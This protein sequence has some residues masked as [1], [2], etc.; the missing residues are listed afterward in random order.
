MRSTS[1]WFWAAMHGAVG[2][3]AA[4]WAVHS[5]GALWAAPASPLL[6]P[7]PWRLPAGAV[8]V[9][10]LAWTTVRATR[11]LVTQTHWAA[12]LHLHLRSELLGMSPSQMVLLAGLSA[13]SE[14]LLFRAV[15]G[16]ALGVVG[17][18]VLFGVIHA[19]PRHSYLPRAG[20]AFA[21][22]LLLSGLYLTSG[23]LLAPV[24][25]H[26]LIN[27]E[28]MQYICNYDPTPL[29]IDRAPLGNM[30]KSEG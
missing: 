19:A 27:Y 11:L 24:V 5:R 17:S 14:E 25:A 2:G 8:L 7:P 23:T 9:L 10:A 13:W 26:W 30:P 29:D 21:M 20:W 1:M 15:L 22:G 18:S 6:L 28:N 16:P 4:L 12:R 3:G